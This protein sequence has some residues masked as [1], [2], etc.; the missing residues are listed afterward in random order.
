MRHVAD[1]AAAL[2][3]RDQV[4]QRVARPVVRTLPVTLGD[5]LLVFPAAHH[6]GALS[7]QVAKRLHHEGGVLPGGRSDLAGEIPDR[8]RHDLAVRRDYNAGDL[9]QKFVKLVGSAR[10]EKIVEI[11]DCPHVIIAVQRLGAGVGWP[12]PGEAISRQLIEQVCFFLAASS[13]SDMGGMHM[14][15]SSLGEAALF[16]DIFCSCVC[17][18]AQRRRGCGRLR[19][20]GDGM[21]ENGFSRQ[22]QFAEFIFHIPVGFQP[23]LHL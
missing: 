6:D 21:A 3:V 11:S 18:T 14:V 7:L 20:H 4:L 1:Q 16:L 5:L 9:G 12:R 13:A 15:A 19:Q 17:A 10:F 8:A 2:S 22:V 23:T